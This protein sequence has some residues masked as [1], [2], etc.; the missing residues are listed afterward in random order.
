MSTGILRLDHRVLG[1]AEEQF[2]CVDAV[3]DGRADVVR[4]QRD[5]RSGSLGVLSASRSRLR[6]VDLAV[7]RVS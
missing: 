7:V 2:R 1:R 4:P 3:A 6:T 5:A